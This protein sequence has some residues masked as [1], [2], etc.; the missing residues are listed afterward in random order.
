[1]ALVE[2][3]HGQAWDYPWR[4]FVLALGRLPKT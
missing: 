2:A 1:M 4:V 3:G